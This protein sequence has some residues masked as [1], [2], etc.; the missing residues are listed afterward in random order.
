MAG[1]WPRA[2][3]TRHR[4]GTPKL[5]VFGVAVNVEARRGDLPLSTYYHEAKRAGT[6]Q[7]SK[8]RA[9]QKHHEDRDEKE[10]RGRREER[11][12]TENPLPSTTPVRPH[13]AHRCLTD[14]RGRGRL[15]IYQPSYLR[16]QLSP[17]QS[18]PCHVSP[19]KEPVASGNSQTQAHG[20]VYAD[21]AHPSRQVRHESAFLRSTD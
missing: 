11:G 19:N 13:R 2:D 21:S 9:L 15:N 8:M 3:T 7:S 6:Q 4:H 17:V 1:G 16:I 20:H 5:P 14:R 10:E 18:N 12:E